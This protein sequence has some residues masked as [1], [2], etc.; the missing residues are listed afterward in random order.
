MLSAIIKGLF[1]GLSISLLIGPIVFALLETTIEKGR[2]TGFIFASG[3]WFSDIIYIIIVNLIFKTFTISTSTMKIGGIIGGF[4]L[5]LFGISAWFSKRNTNNNYQLNFKKIGQAFAKGI[6]IN[7]FNPFVFVLWLSIYGMLLALNYTLLEKVAFYFA[8]LLTV[9]LLDLFKIQLANILI[10][11]LTTNKL[12]L[13]KKV[14]AVI[15]ILFGI[16][17]IARVW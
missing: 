10:K 6:S 8:M 1:F 3:I 12:V 15:L 13:V 17:L 9:A 4:I 2:K 5:V 7:I 16:V 14:A 11:Q